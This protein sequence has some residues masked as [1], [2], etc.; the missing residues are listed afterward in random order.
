M[1]FKKT[2][3][4]FVF[5]CIFTAAFEAGFVFIIRT[6]AK[7]EP[8]KLSQGGVMFFGIAAAILLAAGLMFVKICHAFIGSLSF[9]GRSTSR[10]IDFDA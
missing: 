10:Y 9:T 7:G 2:A 4:I 5:Y 1:S 8:P 3:A 6:A